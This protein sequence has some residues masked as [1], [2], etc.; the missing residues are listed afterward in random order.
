MKGYS[1][2]E[3]AVELAHYIID[4]KDTVRGAARR[5]GISKSTVHKD[6]SER[7]LKI[8]PVLALKVREIFDE[9]KAERHIRG[10]M[11]T[12]LKYEHEHEEKN[13]G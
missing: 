13:V 7:L 2:E 11:A 12:K 5:Y 10:G 8:N 1:I 4:S 6:V 3:R 9:N